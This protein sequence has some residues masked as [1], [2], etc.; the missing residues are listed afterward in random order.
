[1]LQDNPQWKCP[2]CQ[3]SN[4]PKVLHNKPNNQPFLWEC[5]GCGE[6][7]VVTLKTSYTSRVWK[8]VD[9]V[10]DQECCTGGAV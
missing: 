1:M 9:T 5:S 6:T 8:L 3:M 10:D 2:Y 4:Q 7:M